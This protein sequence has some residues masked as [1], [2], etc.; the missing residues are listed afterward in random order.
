MLDIII[1]NRWKLGSPWEKLFSVVYRPSKESPESQM[2]GVLATA[3]IPCPNMS[4]FGTCGDQN[5]GYNH[6]F[7]SSSSQNDMNRVSTERASKFTG[8]SGQFV[9]S[10]KGGNAVPI[11]QTDGL[12][13]FLSAK[14]GVIGSRAVDAMPPPRVIESGGNS[15]QLPASHLISH[16]P[17]QRDKPKTEPVDW[18]AVAL[19]K[20]KAKSTINTPKAEL[21]QR[22]TDLLR[23]QEE[24]T[25][26]LKNLDEEL[27]MLR[28]AKSQPQGSGIDSNLILSASMGCET[29]REMCKAY[30]SS[31]DETSQNMQSIFSQMESTGL[32][33]LSDIQRSQDD[34]LGEIRTAYDKLN[35]LCEHVG[36]EFRATVYQVQKTQPTR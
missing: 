5:C 30:S 1:L 27:E 12:P 20:V 18:K 36:T 19:A 15:R 10:K 33:D 8:G 11:R 25:K 16:I 7:Q 4:R 21:E 34:I 6:G 29:L 26:L 9:G 17:A 28:R 3:R 13:T 2:S 24:K 32:V 35:R 23:Q 14:F 31:V 22:L